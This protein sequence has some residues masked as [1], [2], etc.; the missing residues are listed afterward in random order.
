[1]DPKKSFNH[2]EYELCDE[3]NSDQKRGESGEA[4]E[5][6]DIVDLLLTCACWDSDAPQGMIAIL[7][8]IRAFLW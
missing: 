8:E 3:R 5:L 6:G 4:Q 7:A 2:G 1:M